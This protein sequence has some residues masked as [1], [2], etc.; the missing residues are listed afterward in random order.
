MDDQPSILHRTVLASPVIQH[1]FQCRNADG[2][3]FHVILRS[4]SLVIAN[5]THSLPSRLLSACVIEDKSPDKP[6]RDHLLMCISSGQ[7]LL[8]KVYET[9][10]TPD[11]LDAVTIFPRSKPNL[12]GLGGKIC[13]DGSST[14]AAIGSFAEF[15]LLVELRPLADKPKRFFKEQHVV[16]SAGAPATFNSPR[17]TAL[18]YC[19]NMIASTEED[20][21]VYLSALYANE[22]QRLTLETY[23]WRPKYPVKTVSKLPL[24]IMDLPVFLFFNDTVSGSVILACPR[25]LYLVKFNDML[26]G[27]TT[28]PTCSIDSFPI[29]HYRSEDAGHVYISC[30]DGSILE[31]VATNSTIK[32]IKVVK[33]DVDLGRTFVL[34]EADDE[35]YLLGYGGDASD[36]R[37]LQITKSDT[38]SFVMETIASFPNWAPASDIEIIHGNMYVASGVENTGALTQLNPGSRLTTLY[39]EESDQYDSISSVTFGSGLFPV[40]YIV[41]SSP[42]RSKI[43]QTMY[44]DA[45]SEDPNP[46]FWDLAEDC[47]FEFN[48]KTLHT[49]FTTNGLFVQITPATLVLT[50]LSGHKSTLDQAT[51]LGSVGPNNILA[52]VSNVS[53]NDRTL[54]VYRVATVVEQNAFELVKSIPL[55]APVTLLRV[56]DDHIVVGTHETINFYDI[57]DLT[58]VST[59]LPF[60]PCDMLINSAFELLIGCRTGHLLFCSLTSAGEVTVNSY[61]QFGDTPVRITSLQFQDYI[62]VA[63]DN[64]YILNL[65][66]N[67]PPLQIHNDDSSNQVIIGECPVFIGEASPETAMSVFACF[68]TPGQ[69]KLVDLEL[70]QSV[71]EH[72][73]ELGKTPRR[74]LYLND[75][76]L[77]VV[78]LLGD[79]DPDTGN[80]LAF[81]DLSTRSVVSPNVFM[82]RR[83]PGGV[84]VFSRKE[85]IYCMAEWK[86]SL[87]SQEYRYLVTGS[88]YTTSAKGRLV[89]LS[90][91]VK[92]GEVSLGKQAAWTVPE[93]VFAVCQLSK[94]TLVYSFGRKISVAKFSGPCIEYKS[95]PEFE[96][97]SKVVK[98]TVTTAGEVI[99][100]TMNNG[101]VV[102]TYEDDKFCRVA[103]DSVYR[104]CLNHGVSDSLIAV[105]DKERCVSFLARDD[106]ITLLKPMGKVFLPSFVSKLLSSDH[107]PVWRK[108]P[109]QM[110]QNP[111]ILCLSMSGEITKMYI[112]TRQEREHWDKALSAMKRTKLEESLKNSDYDSFMEEFNGPIN[113]LDSNSSSYVSFPTPISPAPTL[114]SDFDLN[115]TNIINGTSLFQ[116]YYG[117]VSPIID[118]LNEM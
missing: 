24:P 73:I 104:S 86:L 76:N 93:P 99:A 32:V 84:T 68:L 39:S 66:D 112:M 65:A 117:T 61:R 37:L 58:T 109:S 62:L 92:N 94:N 42:I 1:I 91:K 116:M 29:A 98:L 100:S 71:V 72:K 40:S 4:T 96:F 108:Q 28:F 46:R 90:Y 8:V 19:F 16:S 113:S 10:A 26:S 60:T 89:I 20:H 111:S 69:L 48:Q 56:I 44:K 97:A 103:K 102:L 18:D 78:T 30:E 59:D 6:S 110:F 2:V 115:S 38:K 12:N 43:R 105:A 47:G 27:V 5:R 114:W 82:D 52:T 101:V 9:G 87:D 41:V 85:V 13:V 45:I 22:K 70:A 3:P 7:L 75:V 64:V 25:N 35:S 49:G 50:D 79:M 36:G 83:K 77:L 106:G 31:V 55:D 14:L 33:T 51:V 11:V 63:S 53:G 23:L 88:G 118:A 15:V 67:S 74:L 81:I 54:S 34:E 107:H 95:G 21:G 17:S 57:E 80:H